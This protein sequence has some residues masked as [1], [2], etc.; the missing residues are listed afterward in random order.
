MR[1]FTFS[2]NDIYFVMSLDDIIK[3]FNNIQDVMNA[4]PFIAP[5]ATH[6]DLIKSSQYGIL[7]HAFNVKKSS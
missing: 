1:P 4:L 7:V 3:K 2:N 5:G 6:D